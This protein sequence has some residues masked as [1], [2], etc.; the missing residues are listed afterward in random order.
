MKKVR[1]TMQASDLSKEDLRTLIQ[2]FREWELRTPRSDVTMLLFETD[3]ELT[4]EEAKEIFQGIYPPFE[5]QQLFPTD[6]RQLNLGSRSI[7][8]GGK[9]VGTCDDMSLTLA[10]ASDEDIELLANAQSISMVKMGEG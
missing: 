7:V 8:V 10:E 6:F 3:P 2:V 5:Q 1:M 9:I 4:T